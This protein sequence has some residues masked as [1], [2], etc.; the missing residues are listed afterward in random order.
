VLPRHSSIV[1]TR[2]QARNHS[3]DSLTFRREFGRYHAWGAAVRLIP[4]FI[5][6]SGVTLLVANG[7]TAVPAKPAP[8]IRPISSLKLSAVGAASPS[9][10]SA[11]CVPGVSGPPRFAVNYILPPNDAYYTYVRCDQCAPEGA[12]I[13][14]VHV[15]LH[16]PVACELPAT[17]SFVAAT[18]D[19]TCLQPDTLA[20][21]SPPT[22][23]LLSASAP[24]DYDFG[25]TL[26]QS[27][28]VSG[29]VFLRVNF[30]SDGGPEC[31]SAATRPQLLTTSSCQPCRSWN[32]SVAGRQDLCQV[33]LPGRPVMYVV[34]E[35]CGVPTRPHSWGQLKILY[36]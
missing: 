20:T 16:F 8:E 13:R 10:G 3:A 9:R 19:T 18:G 36:R 5:V 14:E 17:L 29:D 2:R 4:M 26:P 32:D 24:G 15:A 33:L 23:Y 34:F 22:P 1:F 12:S 11:L 25:L 31:S 21:L 6:S 30:T 27:V 7:A 28:H 35:S